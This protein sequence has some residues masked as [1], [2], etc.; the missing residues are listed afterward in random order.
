MTQSTREFRCRVTMLAAVF[1]LSAM[2]LTAREV[3]ADEATASTLKSE[4]SDSI[5]QAQTQSENTQTNKNTDVTNASRD[6]AGLKLEEIT[7]TA[8]RRQESENDVPLSMVAKT[9]EYLAEH[10]IDDLS[11]LDKIVPGYV[12]S[13]LSTDPAPAIFLRGI[14]TYSESD[15]VDA[16]VGTAIDGVVTTGRSSALSGEFN[17]I[18]RVEVLRGPQGTL[19]GKNSSGGL[20]NVVTKDPTQE[21]T[22]NFNVGTGSYGAFKVNGTISGGLIGDELLGRLS[23]YKS[24]RDGYIT[25]VLSGQKLLN[26]DQEGVRG[27]LL[28]LPTDGTRL[29]LSSYALNWHSNWSVNTAFSPIRTLGPLSNAGDLLASDIA[30]PDNDKV[31]LSGDGGAPYFSKEWG[32]TLQ[33]DQQLGPYTLTSITAYQD[34]AW[35]Q[36]IRDLGSSA[37]PDPNDFFVYDLADERQQQWSEELRVASP[38]G[39]GQI[40]DYVTGIYLYDLRWTNH[41]NLLLDAI[42][43]P[44]PTG[45]ITVGAGF[46]SIIDTLN[47]A[48]FGEANIH[49]SDTV[50][51]I[52]G[53][54]WTHERKDM[55]LENEAVPGVS[56]PI[57]NSRFPGVTDTAIV[58]QNWSWRGG[59]QWKP[60]ADQMLYGTASRGFKGPGF[61]DAFTPNY[62]GEVQTVKPEIATTFEVGAKSVWLDRR[63]TTDLA[64]F[65]TEIKDFQAETNELITLP[66][67]AGQVSAF[68]LQNAGKI[69]SQGV[70]FDLRAVP[71]EHL[72][73][74]FTTAYVDAIY[75]EFR[76]AQCYDGQTVG[77]VNGEQDL[78]GTRLPS[79][80]KMSGDLGAGYDFPVWTLP[81]DGFVRADYSFRSSV[82]W[83]RANAPTTIE[84]G[85]G[86]LGGSIGVRSK[87]HHLGLTVFG[88]N[89]TNK[90]HTGGLG[91]TS[92]GG[93]GTINQELAPDY[94]RIW[95]LNLNYNF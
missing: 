90:F 22:G 46:H 35:H 75:Q 88:K 1:A 83:S 68:V 7:V 58:A 28:F 13:A 52:S 51:L 56:V 20:V 32:S 72:T 89:L 64:V 31:K 21:L 8:R 69:R 38:S 47:Y 54:R 61:N 48:G 57:L 12:F 67:G 73:V 2:A 11:Q 65:Y 45:L 17:D 29:R 25:N 50:T 39:A 30:G 93:F 66:N 9:G 24:E 34:W 55:F 84:D 4:N 79:T 3:R 43:L 27:T 16:S 23:V 6:V 87:D 59:V 94:Q 15:G 95:G 60:T 14:G 18:E 62:Q 10:H 78:S 36:D 53:T 19:F 40:V 63:L 74:D 92:P 86:L 85:Y 77:C 42:D 91:Y 37:E 82:Q 81:V 71:V 44:P 76:G 41:L 26:D 49:V 80:P 5:S 33:W 70:E